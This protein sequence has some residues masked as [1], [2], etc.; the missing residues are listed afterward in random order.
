MAEFVDGHNAGVLQLAGDPGLLDEPAGGCG[1]VGQILAEDFHRDVPTQVRVVAADDGTHAAAADFFPQL[2]PAGAGPRRLSALTVRRVWLV[3]GRVRV[4][5]QG[6]G[7]RRLGLV[8][9]RQIGHG[10]PTPRPWRALS[11]AYRAVPDSM[12]L[13]GVQLSERRESCDV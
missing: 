8:A 3:G 9:F 12:H 2:E 5:W 13:E 1:V 4:R 10:R 11:S 6:L 7:W